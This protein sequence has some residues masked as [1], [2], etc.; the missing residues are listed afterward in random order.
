MS[1]LLL[2]VGGVRDK[3]VQAPGSVFY[4]LAGMQR[5]LGICIV[6]GGVGGAGVIQ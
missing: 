5:F 4:V 2:G 6:W 1:P 3:T